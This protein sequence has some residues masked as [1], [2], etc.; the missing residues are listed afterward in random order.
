MDNETNNPLDILMWVGKEYY[1][2][3]SFIKEAKTMGVSKRISKTSIPEGIVSGQ[4]RLFI[5][6]PEAI[7]KVT[8]DDKDLSDLLDILWNLGLISQDDIEM[9]TWDE[10]YW[11][12][13]N[14]QPMDFVPE[15]ML[16]IVKALDSADKNLRSQI[17]KD[18][19]I[20]WHPGVIGY[21][22]I[23][24]L[25]YV[26]KDDE[27]TLPPGLSHMDGYIKP[28]IVEMDEDDASG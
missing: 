16:T 26:C 11:E 28:V 22:Y 1:T 8:A 13:E 24:G 4:S 20:L 2:A 12:Y 27:N 3:G 7:L 10:V 15:G 21:S 18:F 5:C 9:A 23:V 17:V 6:H 14:L 19:E 25:E